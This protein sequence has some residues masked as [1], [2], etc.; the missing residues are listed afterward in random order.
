MSTLL[1][2]N[3]RFF[4][5]VILVMLAAGASALF[6]IG[7]QEDP[8]ITN[9]FA[10]VITPYPGAD[11][12]RVE[13][14]V[15]QKIEDEL[16]E[17]SEIENITSVSRTGISVIQ[18]ELSQFISKTQI[19]QTWSEIRDALSDAERQFPQGAASAGFDND[20]TGAYT[21][22]TALMAKPGTSLQP[23]ILRRTAKALQD[24]LRNVAGTKN[25]ELFG[26]QDEEI[27]VS[28]NAENLISLGLTFET[29]S[30]AIAA[31]DAKVRAGQVRG[32]KQDLLIEL[33]GELKT[34]E[35]IRSIPIHQANDGRIVRVSDVAT[36]NRGLRKP[37]QSL[38]IVNGKDAVL[39]AARMEDDLQVDAWSNKV[40]AAYSKF[41]DEMPAGIELKPLFDQ[42]EYTSSR[43]TNVFGNMLI[44]VTIV[45]GVLFL[46]L[47]ARAALIVAM[48]IPLAT[49]VSIAG[50]KAAGIP[51]HQMSV[52]GLIVALGLLVDA[53]I[54][55]T[56]DV[57]K[58]L[59]SGASRLLAVEG[60]VHRLALPLL[61][62]TVTTVLAFM[63]MA[64]LPGP[65]GDFIGAVAISV[66]TMLVVS[67]ILAITVTPAMAGWLLKDK[68]ESEQSS[69]IATG[70]SFRFLGNI[71]KKILE[72]ALRHPRLAILGALILP[73]M[74]FASFPTLKPQFFPGVDRDQFHIQLKLSN[75]A[76]IEET[77][78]IVKKAESI[79]RQE[80]GVTSLTW[81]IG[82]SAPAFYYNMLANQDKEPS[83]AEALVSTRSAKATEAILDRLQR[84]LD[85]ALPTARVIVRGLVQGP[86]VNAPVEI[87]IVGQDLDILRQL[88]NKIRL[89][90]LDV[91][92]VMQ[93]RMQLSPAAPKVLVD[94]EEEK[95][96]LVGLNLGQAARQLEAQLEGQTG[97]SV[98]EGSEELPVRVRVAGDKRKSIDNIAR[99]NLVGPNGIR[100]AE[101]GSYPGIPITALGE[102]KVHP[103]ESPIYRR[104][105]LRIN[106]VQAFVERNMLPEQ[107]L[108]IIQQRIKESGLKLPNGYHF[109]VGGDS[110]ARDETLRNLLGSM[111]LIITLTITAIVLT[112]GSYRLSI[113]T[114]FVAGLSMGLSL[115][116]LSLFQYPFGIQA[117]VGV[118]GSIGVSIN[119]AIIL[120][121][122]LQQNSASLRGD[123]TH[124]TK[125]VMAQ[126]RHIISTT[127]TTFGGFLPLILEG[128]GFWPP[129]AMSIAGGVL[130]STVVSFFFVPPV[131]LLLARSG[132]IP[133][134]ISKEEI[135][136][137][138]PGK[139]YQP[140]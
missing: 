65:P 57:R 76:A 72:L 44:G 112:F 123:I 86:P 42:A 51:I 4:A 28:V 102:L 116:A 64:L 113:V 71:F 90:M 98:I 18:L 111:G 139:T 12:S 115:L 119:A 32:S 79:I 110:D 21:A 74:G 83:F 125:V 5:L 127:V 26:E 69:W 114:T 92:G 61:A 136:E 107:A 124:V 20:R 22:I 35:R 77:K 103:A 54:V 91:P 104:N 52:T 6:T 1:F 29:V 53:A 73:L 100:Q 59:A 56:D 82:E 122:A 31:A 10:T 68:T 37:A 30:L 55:M 126:G 140:A 38:A 15:T 132:K 137:I 128:G 101:L 121:T 60:A 48:I 67:F 46:T 39:I 88:G 16:K 36:V 63:P 134:P 11:P 66:M 138:S 87:R 94:L 17:I 9:L 13:A 7:R 109:E 24:Q 105:G 108:R 2:R 43:L 75:G 81:V 70:L 14:L 118:I 27:T 33:A 99:I 130:L 34:L 50:L 80:A 93:A 78:R 131:F 120:M 25:V 135:T 62:S 129:F 45:I 96:R 117:V 85:S 23:A 3:K 58:R 84:R 8:T 95:V 19:E 89:I 41:T 106:T 133:S 40:K 49:L 97:G 47:G